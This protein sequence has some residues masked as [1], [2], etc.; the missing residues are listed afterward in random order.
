MV[1]AE[2]TAELLDHKGNIV[3]IT[4]DSG[5]FPELRVQLAAFEKTLKS[6]G[7]ISI[8]HIEDVAAKDPKYGIGRGL[9]AARLLKTVAKY[10]TADAIVSFIGVPNFTSAEADEFSKAHPKF[11]AEVRSQ[12][13]MLRLLDK[14]VLQVAVVSRFTFPAPGDSK[15]PHKPREWFDRYFQV[16]TPAPGATKQ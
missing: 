16:V 6:S 5:Q 9:S 10:P 15:H 11:I 13:R 4:I 7:A 8:Q 12:E 3:V 1:L 2:Q 14:G